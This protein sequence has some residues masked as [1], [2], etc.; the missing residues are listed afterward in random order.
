MIRNEVRFDTMDDLLAALGSP[1]MPE[2][3]ADTKGF[4]RFGRS[5][6]FPMQH[7]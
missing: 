2:L 3:R 4:P 1:V 7:G 6:H 5:T